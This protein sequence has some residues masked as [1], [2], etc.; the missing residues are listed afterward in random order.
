MNAIDGSGRASLVP[1][2]AFE[3]LPSAYRQPATRALPVVQYNAAPLGMAGRGGARLRGVQHAQG[4]KLCSCDELASRPAR[5]ASPPYITP[6]R[7]SLRT[8]GP[9]ILGPATLGPGALGPGTLDSRTWDCGS[10]DSGSWDE[11]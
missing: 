7:Y 6:T 1:R 8:M 11:T 5:P 2:G 9:G 10:C 3:P 4:R